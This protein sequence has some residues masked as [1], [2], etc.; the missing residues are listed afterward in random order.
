ML[1]GPKLLALILNQ[2]GRLRPLRYTWKLNFDVTRN[3]NSHAKGFGWEI[4]NHL[5]QVRLA[6]TLHWMLQKT[7]KFL[8]CTLFAMGSLKCLHPN[9]NSCRSNMTDCLKVV[10]LINGNGLDLTGVFLFYL[11]KQKTWHKFCG[12]L[13]FSH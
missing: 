2:N 9:C 3:P 8:R 13:F 7:Q 4:C 6:A 11:K 5:E 12:C 10:K 1:G